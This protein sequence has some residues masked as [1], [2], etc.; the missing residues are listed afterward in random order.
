MSRRA[1]N[2]HLAAVCCVF[3][4]MLSAGAYAED[5]NNGKQSDCTAPPVQQNQD[6]KQGRHQEPDSA[7]GHRTDLS[8]CNGVVKPPSTGD[9]DLVRPAPAAGDTPVIPP[10]DIPQ[11]NQ[12]PK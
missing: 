4:M 2:I 9:T 11:Q 3:G 8:D 10:G 1:R 7:T 6:Q 12:K 5:A